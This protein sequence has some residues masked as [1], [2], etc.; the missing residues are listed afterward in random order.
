VKFIRIPACIADL[1]TRLNPE[2]SLLGAAPL[3]LCLALIWPFGGGRK[4]Q[5]MAGTTTPGAN[6]TITIKTSNNRNTALDIKAQNL[7][8]P[9]SLTPAE[10]VYVVWIQPP[11]QNAQNA[12]QLRVNQNEQGELHTET[13]YKRFKVFITAEQNAQVQEPIG[14][15]ILSADIAQH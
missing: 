5:M 6:A 2:T 15:S 3:L 7:A 11:G 9:S 10:N 14:P 1:R 13:A 12:G 4:V 8:A